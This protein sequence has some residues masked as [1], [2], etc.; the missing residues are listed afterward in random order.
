VVE[1]E[2][3]VPSPSGSGQ[4]KKVTVRRNVT[5][6]YL[7][8]VVLL[9]IGFVTTPILTHQLGILRYGVWALIGSLIP[10]LEILELGFASAT[11]AFVSRH[12]ELEDDD[13]VA[14][15][16]NTSFLVLSVLGVVAFAGVVVF[17]IFLPDIITDI[18]K[19][20]VGQAQFLLLLLAFDM[21]LSI[22]LDTFGGALS[23]LQRFDLLNYSLIGVTVSQAIGWVIVLWLHGGLIALGV[24]T[25]AMS[26]LGQAS[27]LIMVHRLLPW[28]RFSFR[29]FD[30]SLVK[31]FTTASSWYSV[32][33][34]ADAVL[35]LSDVLIV[36]AAAG[37]RAAAVYA[38]AQRL[39]QLPLKVVQ[40]RTALLFVKAGT[41]VARD[42]RAGLRDAVDEVVGFV[43][44]L[45]IPAAIALGFLAG[46]AIEAWVGPLYRDAVPVIGLLVIAAV[47]QSW[48][49]P[50]KMSIN[51]AGLPKLTAAVF[52]S[53]AVIHVGLGIAL[54]ARYG[55][56]GMAEAALIGTVLMEGVLL[57]PLAYRWLD[58]SLVRRSLRAARTL[59]LPT[60]VTGALA[61][62]VG[63]SG[64]RLYVFTDTH[65]RFV[66]LVTVAATGLA[67]V[68]VFYAI[69]L[70]SVPAGQRQVFL[71]HFRTSL[72]RL[73]ARL[74]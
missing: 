57:L 71:A 42:N 47:V 39:A 41:L 23:A 62:F 33:Q 37:V 56:L 28:F 18:P 64:G 7:V 63:R 25:V 26:L 20:L 74:H 6:N 32:G 60:L 43:L 50:L 70:V 72:G 29:G 40:P 49:Q 31:R 17:A 69:L 21:A 19:S 13:Q 65:G 35:A 4:R 5:T 3:Q 22:P 11:I 58:D 44:A 52:G 38:V 16:L 36:G 10:F 55:A 15:T 51:G 61:W 54:A 8:A 45:S 30:R 24:V 12:L 67:L 46:P 2:P 27:R 73:A 1:A 14:R 53:E 59:T 34:I 9:V 66:G 48:A 68:I